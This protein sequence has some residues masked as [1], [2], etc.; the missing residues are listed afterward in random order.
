VPP[1]PWA[2]PTAPAIV[3]ENENIQPTH[4][5]QPAQETAYHIP[6]YEQFQALHQ[7]HE[8]FLHGRL[9]NVEIQGP[10]YNLQTTAPSLVL[11]DHLL[12][13]ETLNDLRTFPTR[14]P[15][16]LVPVSELESTMARATTSAAPLQASSPKITQGV[17]NTP[18]E[19]IQLPKNLRHQQS[20][21]IENIEDATTLPL[22]QHKHLRIQAFSSATI[23]ARAVPVHSSALIE[24]NHSFLCQGI[25]SMG[26]TPPTFLHERNSPASREEDAPTFS[27][28]QQKRQCGQE[29]MTTPHMDVVKN[30]IG[31]ILAAIA[32]NPGEHTKAVYAQIGAIENVS[33][34][35]N[36]AFR[37]SDT[38]QL[39]LFYTARLEM[40][41]K[42][43]LLS[44][45]TLWYKT[46]TIIM[47]TNVY[48]EPKESE[49]YK[50]ATCTIHSHSL[51]IV[52]KAVGFLMKRG[53]IK[54]LQEQ[55]NSV[56]AKIREGSGSVSGRS[57]EQARDTVLPS[58]F[59]VARLHECLCRL[60]DEDDQS[61]SDV[62]I[63][64]QRVNKSKEKR[65]VYKSKEKRKKT[66]K[67]GSGRI[68]PER[69]Y[70]EIPKTANAKYMLENFGIDQLTHDS[71]LVSV[72][73]FIIQS[74]IN[75]N[76]R[77]AQTRQ[78]TP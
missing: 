23:S 56:I 75:T 47:P 49:Y 1:P 41:P 64:W 65:R 7:A 9:N 10:T 62:I 6:G 69:R 78:E 74:Y 21:S 68:S 48:L 61:K 29:A 44:I 77:N 50:L 42:S 25:P 34:P 54:G 2:S 63:Q 76:G 32:L 26:A 11:A 73:S 12:V 37:L 51:E 36:G 70:W 35:E 22:P 71:L 17:R 57:K 18:N 24:P 67:V 72:C 5:E 15:T 55:T 4:P 40:M 8:D 31:D 28:T 46:A 45:V 27:E 33:I 3:T 38:E 20:G 14:V 53:W 59:Y 30:I 58:L 13:D 16:H 43:M 19:S 66:D 39:Q 60:K 52:P